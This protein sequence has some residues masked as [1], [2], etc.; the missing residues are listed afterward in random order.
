MQRVDG[1][2]VL[3]GEISGKILKPRAIGTVC[4]HC[5][6]KVIFTLL[7]FHPP[8][9]ANSIA[10]TAQCPACR[11][12]SAFW[13]INPAGVSSFSQAE[14]FVHPAPAN[15]ASMPDQ[16][17]TLPEPLRRALSSAIEAYNA[18][19]Y[20]AAAVSGRRTLE[21]IFKYLVP[22]E[23]RNLPLA[24][25]IDLVRE[26]NDLSA[27]LSALSHAIRTGGNLGAHFDMEHEPDERVARQI[28]E[29]LSYLVTFLYVLP[30]RIERLESDL[31]RPPR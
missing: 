11:K 8:G 30:A 28:V 31:N 22:E 18:G 6:A 14:I 7:N 24:R 17:H 21:G 19:I 23:N 16:A 26:K 29:L 27:P 15:F 2:S 5:G 4:G 13:C 9:P 20:T 12:E 25:L 3:G 1:A 10:A